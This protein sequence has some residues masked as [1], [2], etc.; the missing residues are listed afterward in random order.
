MTTCRPYQSAFRR[1]H[2]LPAISSKYRFR[3]GC[4]CDSCFACPSGSNRWRGVLSRTTRG[5]GHEQPF[6]LPRN[7]GTRRRERA[8]HARRSNEN[9]PRMRATPMMRPRSHAR[10]RERML[11]QRREYIDECCI[12]FA[13]RPSGPVRAEKGSRPGADKAS[14]RL[15]QAFP[16]R[17]RRFRRQRA[18]QIPWRRPRPGSGAPPLIGRRRCLPA[19]AP[20]VLHVAIHAVRRRQHRVGAGRHRVLQVHQ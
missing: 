9:R 10:H 3:H 16:R 17:R 19:R 7:Q 5:D 18:A 13:C 11:R 4:A 2:I 14:D 6:R 8:R 1:S 12:G 15:R 20:P